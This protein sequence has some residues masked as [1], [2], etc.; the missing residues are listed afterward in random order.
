MILLQRKPLVTGHVKPMSLPPG[1]ADVMQDLAVF[2]LL[3]GLSLHQFFELRQD[4]IDQ[5]LVVLAFSPVVYMS[6]VDRALAKRDF[7]VPA[8]P[9]CSSMAEPASDGDNPLGC[10][11]LIV[12][13]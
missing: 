8:L 3:F 5:T 1:H 4:R 6:T 12:G 2:D 9:N 11:S 7:S 10:D 13:S